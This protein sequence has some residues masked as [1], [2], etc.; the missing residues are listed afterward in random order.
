MISKERSGLLRTG[1]GDEVG[2]LPD[3]TH[4]PDPVT[5]AAPATRPR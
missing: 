2:R 1:E 5:L 3:V 4:G